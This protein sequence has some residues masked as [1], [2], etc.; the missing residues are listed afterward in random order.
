V[1]EPKAN[2]EASSP[3]RDGR[4]PL[5]AD[6]DKAKFVRRMFRAIAPRYDLLNHVLSLNRD[7]A[8]RRRTVDRLAAP[9]SRDAIVL[10]LCAGTLDLA[11]ELARRPAF[12]GRIIAADFAQ[13]MLARGTPKI[14]RLAVLPVCADALSL[15]LPD[16]GCDAAMVAFG[17]RNLGSLDAGFR[18]L[19]RVLRPGGRVAVLEFATPTWR[20]FRALYLLYFRRILP[21]VGRLVSRHGSAYSYLPASV[22]EFPAPDALAALMHTTGFR[23]VTWERMTGGI[24]ALHVG[25]RA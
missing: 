18:E 12:G 8:W 4:G 5:P 10:D 23:D 20:P 6:A 13:E 1:I 11:V 25:T 15:P 3:D 2:L 16:A 24:V 7:R 22:L 19:A 21:A 9:A 14:K 17:V